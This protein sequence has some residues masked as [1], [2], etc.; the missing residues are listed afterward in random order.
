MWLFIALVGHFLNAFV[1][2][3]DK[4]FVEKILP[5][6]R[7]LAFISGAS[8]IF[9]FVLIPWFLRPGGFLTIFAAIFSGAILVI[10]LI[11]FFSALQKDEVSRVVPAIG[12]ITPLFTFALSYGI[13]GERLGGEALVAFILLA[14]GGILIAAR[15]FGAIFKEKFY[16]LFFLEIFV[17]FLFALSFVLQKYAFEGTDDLSAFLWSRMGAVGAALPLLFYTE[18]REKIKFSSV[19]GNGVRAGTLYV[20]SRIFAGIAPLVVLL[21]ISFGSAS[22]VNAMQGVQYGFLYILALIFARRFPDIF[23]EEFS[24]KVIIQKSAALILIITGLILLAR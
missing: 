15:S 2:I 17:G 19:R 20:L 18:V 13:L 1:F 12:S 10:A 8:G 7:A 23:E 22:L 11:F 21:A 4:A 14:L 24:K 3:T 16:S 9:T 6:P 5:S